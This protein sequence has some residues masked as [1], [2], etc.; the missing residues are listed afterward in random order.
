MHV[1]L[2][3]YSKR[4]EIMVPRLGILTVL[5]ALIL[6]VA[7]PLLWASWIEDGVTIC[8][9]VNDQD[10]PM[11][12]SDGSGGAIITWHDVRGG[13]A[14][15][16]YAQRIDS[17]GNVLWTADG[18][19][20]CTALYIQYDPTIVSDG[21]GG[22]IITWQD[23]RNGTDYDIYTQ[24]VNV[25][26][27]IQWTV[28]GVPI[29]TAAN[30]QFYPTI[31]SDGSG[32]AVIT[33]QDYRSGAGYDIYTQRVDDSGN[34]QWT[35]DGVTICTAGNDQLY[36]KIISDASGGAIITWY[37]YR[38]GNNDIFAQSVDVSGN[39]RWTAHGVIICSATDSQRN[40]AIAT[41]GAG[42]AV[43]IWHDNRSGTDYNIYA[44]RVDTAGNVQWTA[45][46]VAVCSAANNQLR[47]TI[48][49]DGTGRAMISWYD[50]RNGTDYNI[51]TQCVDTSGVVQWT[52]D[53]IPICTAAV[54]QYY[55]T[56]ISDGIGGVVIAW[57]DY[58]SGA[59]D[60]YAQRVDATGTA[61]WTADGV[62]VCTAADD[63]S[64]PAIIS[65]G[66]GGAI[67][68][69]EDYRN[70]S[71][72]DIYVGGVNEPGDIKVPTFLAG[73]SCDV[74]NGVVIVRWNL[75]ETEQDMAFLIERSEEKRNEWHPIFPVEI[76]LDGFGYTFV[77]RSCAAGKTYQYRVIVVER[78]ERRILFETDCVTVPIAA[79]TLDQNSP[80][81]FKLQTVIS[82][83][84][85]MDTRVKL[86]IYDI[87]GR[88]VAVLLDGIRPAGANQIGWDGRNNRGESVSSGVYLYRLESE[89]HILT[90]KMMMIK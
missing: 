18:V 52:A 14:Y 33:W 69:W 28:D 57:D 90:R 73:F 80:N 78:N 85:P 55:P 27:N 17:L 63:Q 11:I 79:L 61:Q 9:A 37:D 88:S 58:R 16:I 22:A 54:G 75:S 45:D 84:L 62:A 51:Y 26:G 68:V 81:P 6:F 35:A 46:G 42:G 48:V 59:Y 70:V 86:G 7:T 44:Q 64:S 50:Y 10:S 72:Y 36:P 38:Y 71:H 47:P 65:D 25:S 13:S 76:V 31:V 20:I 23:Y 32:G 24:R 89:K 30:A 87:R 41:D 39:V 4:R 21:S 15:D 66:A 29:C 82:F 1:G 2:I 5:F 56:I 3:L 83:H 53:G 77:D 19:P 60:I 49:Y 67:I 40:P 12:V 74:T 34:V 8:T 43:I